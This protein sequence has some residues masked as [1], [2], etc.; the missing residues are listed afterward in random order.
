MDVHY[1]KEART[2]G[3][4]LINQ[5]EVAEKRDAV[6]QMFNASWKRQEKWMEFLKTADMRLSFQQNLAIFELKEK[7]VE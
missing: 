6:L 2:G 5:D 1:Y 3:K 4:R 7:G